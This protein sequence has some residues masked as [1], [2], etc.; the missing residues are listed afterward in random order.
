MPVIPST[1][2]DGAT[3]SA[4]DRVLLT[5]H[6]LFYRDGIRA[7]GIDRVIADAGVT[8][9][10]FYRHFP[11]KNDL[12]LAF[13]GHRHA[14]WMAWFDAALARHGAGRRHRLA[15]LPLA[16]AEWFAD[17]GFRGCA[18]LNSV[19]ELGPS[20]P[21]VRDIARDHKRDMTAAIA[22]LMPDSPQRAR[23]AEALALAVDGA[24]LHAQFDSADAALE[25]LKRCVQ[26]VIG[27]SE[28][29]GG[30]GDA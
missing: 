2:A 25:P 30:H 22:S 24:I 1:P 13:L 4:R 28:S 16:L 21:E 26:W 18:F 12:V 15:G 9:V 3:A 23:D 5:A 11:S 14:H 10:T 7:T 20:L 27:R 19:G 8:K 17:P 6:D 29:A